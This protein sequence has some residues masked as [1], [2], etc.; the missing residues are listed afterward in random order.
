MAC[1]QCKEECK[2]GAIEEKATFGYC[3]YVI[4]QDKCK[5]CGACLTVNCPGECIIKI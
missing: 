2:H 3:Q 5:Q 4:N 1:G